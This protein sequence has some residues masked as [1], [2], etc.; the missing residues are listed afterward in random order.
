VPPPMLHGVFVFVMAASMLVATYLQDG[1]R[2][3]DEI[4][5]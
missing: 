5:D 1:P 4:V 2:S 3:G